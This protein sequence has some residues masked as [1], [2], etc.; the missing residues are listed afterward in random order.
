MTTRD[1][2]LRLASREWLAKYPFH[3][4]M[5][6]RMEVVHDTSVP[7]MAVSFERGRFFLHANLEA[8]SRAPQFVAGILLHEVHHVALGH[9]THSKFRDGIEHAEVM[10]TCMEL[11]ANDG[12]AE[13][14][15]N[16]I[17]WEQFARFGVRATQST[18]ERYALLVPIHRS[19][20]L[21]K[22]LRDGGADN[23][24]DHG[25]W[26]QGEGTSAGALAKTREVV[27]R[28]L[29]EAK[30]EGLAPDVR[31]A[32]VLP[33][34]LLEALGG[35]SAP[36]EASSIDWRAALE[37]LVQRLR[38]PA[39]TWARPNRRFM[40]RIGAIPGRSYRTGGS[41]RPSVLAVIDTSASITRDDLARI[42]AEFDRIAPYARVVVCECDTEV[43][44][45]YPF[46]NRIDAVEG[47]GG[48]DLRPPF[49]R[50]L[51][52]REAID[53]VVYFTDGEGPWPEHAPSV[54]ALWV[55]VGKQPF[56]CPWG[57]RAS[58]DTA[59]ERRDF[60]RDGAA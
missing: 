27:E 2:L 19:G 16:P 58:L 21:A 31:I 50:T 52:A 35:T 46:A 30:R 59:I 17:V 24:D 44:R 25:P 37:G 39:R 23:V 48:T 42:A 34:R 38:A 36:V 10:E 33:G 41:A 9:L 60:H 26:R 29:D 43:T 55:L 49:E 28:S 51:L 54:P 13:P 57:E 6:A 40:D 45:V 5:I 53:A 20:A 11:S 3:A 12:I 1:A 22:A 8:L 18:L 7:W 4:A 14:L 47:R 56:G 32:G 15:P